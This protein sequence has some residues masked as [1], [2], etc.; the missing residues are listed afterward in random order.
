MPSRAAIRHACAGAFCFNNQMN[1]RIR[2]EVERYLSVKCSCRSR[3]CGV[4]FCGKF[5]FFRDSWACTGFRAFHCGGYL[6]EIR[7]CKFQ[8]CSL[9]P[10]VHLCVRTRSYDCPRHA[11]PRKCPG[12]CHRRHRDTPCLCAMGRRA[13][14]NARFRLRLR[15]VEIRRPAPPVV[16]RQFCHPKR[17]E[18][19][20]QK[21]RLHGAIAKSRRWLCFSHQGISFLGC[22]AFIN[23]NGGC[24]ESTWADRSHRSRSF[25]VEIR[26]AGGANFSFLHQLGHFGPGI[27]DRCPVSIGPNKWIEVDAFNTQRR[28]EASHSRRMESGLSTRRGSS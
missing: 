8:R 18:A 5:P 17:G 23:E 28:S 2:G 26:D 13:S 7:G 4:H 19:V 14:R 11:R 1:A 20:R 22:P 15:F 10:A 9:N 25:R 6:F 12:N 16:L 21:S 24:R 27:L 3:L